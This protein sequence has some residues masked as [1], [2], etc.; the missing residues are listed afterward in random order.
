MLIVD[1]KPKRFAV[2]HSIPA[3]SFVDDC[4]Y[5]YWCENGK[6]HSIG[7]IEENESE[8][9][10]RFVYSDIREFVKVGDKLEITNG[11]PRSYLPN[12]SD[13][14]EIMI[15]YNRLLKGATP[16]LNLHEKACRYRDK[17]SELSIFLNGNV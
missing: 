10:P 17:A 7:M 14:F 6:L 15:A 12:N 11:S 16:V 1:D 9:G 2:V 5:T 4:G 8:T 13:Y 3:V